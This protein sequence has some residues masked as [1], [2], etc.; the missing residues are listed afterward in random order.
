M[1]VIAYILCGKYFLQSVLRY[2]SMLVSGLN[3]FCSLS[4]SGSLSGVHGTLSRAVDIS[5]VGILS[6][7]SEVTIK[8][9][10][11]GKTLD[12][13]NPAHILLGVIALSRPIRKNLQ[14]FNLI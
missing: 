13:P 12:F 5:G 11:K 2:S 10:L 14:K 9:S 8:F 3:G 4:T 7:S 6:G 1:Q